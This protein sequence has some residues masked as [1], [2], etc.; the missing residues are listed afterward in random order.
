MGVR[1]GVVVF[2]GSNCDRDTLHAL[3]SPG[4]SR[5][6]CGTR[7]DARRRRGVVLPGGFA[8]R[9]LPAGRR[10]RAVQPDHARGRRVRRRGRPRPWHLQRVPGPGRGGLVPGALLRNASLRFAG[11]GSRSSAGAA[12]TRRSRA[13]RRT[14][15]AAD[16]GRPRRGSLYADRRRRCHARRRADR[17]CSGTS[18][19]RGARGP[20]DPANPNGSIRGSRA[21]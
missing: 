16:A 5:S 6:R 1:I 17:S 14:S 13:T 10:H 21:S 12:R 7:S 19:R 15:A 11:Q 18:T 20:D 8:L 3:A 4:P 9:R 2:P